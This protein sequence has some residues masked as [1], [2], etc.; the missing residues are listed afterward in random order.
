MR[1]IA[2]ATL[3]ALGSTGCGSSVASG[4]CILVDDGFGPPGDVPI[5]VEV[6]AKGLEVPW[7]VAFL[8]EGDLLVSERPGRVRV[9]TKDGE[10]RPP[11]AKPDVS[12]TAEGGLLGLTLHPDFADNG[13]FYVYL[14]A[15]VGGQNENRVEQYTLSADRLT[16]TFQKVVFGGISA[17]EFHDGGRLRFGPDG[18]LYVGTGDGRSPDRS[19]DPDDPG[20]KILRLTP[21]GEVP[22][23]NP[24]PGNPAFI[25]GI[26][27]TQGFDWLDD[28]S[29]VITDHGP[30][31]EYMDRT[32]HDEV[33]VAKGGDNLGW[34][35]HW[36]CEEA[37]G[38]VTP[39]ITW[40]E[41]LPP[42]G[43]ALYRGSAIPEWQGALAIGALRAEHLQIVHF[44]SED[45][46]RV[47]AH[48]VYLPSTHGRL[49]DVV[50]GPDGALW[51]TTSNCDGR[52]ACGPE[53][54]EI[55][56]ITR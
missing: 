44:D 37:S 52:G 1:R 23:D 34:P 35:T 39:S 28:G 21:E 56:R 5:Q 47:T 13:I 49:R 55:L 17:A 11:V 19:Q 25:L 16:A 38:F 53:G 42:G 6:V 18:M 51:V 50:M 45:P 2:F 32:G 36:S 24:L 41:A 20:G 26:R 15:S 29:M 27:N 54:D 46:R 3:L 31:G 43:A 9:V 8:P 12:P 4:R 10:L 33:N 40:E 30:S 22:S 14:T 7:S 48:E